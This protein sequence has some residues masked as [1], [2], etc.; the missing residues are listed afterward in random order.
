MD[1]ATGV[2]TVVSSASQPTIA[3]VGAVG[4]SVVLQVTGGPP[5]STG[6]ITA[7]G[8]LTAPQS[9]WTTIAT[10]VFDMSGSFTCTNAFNTG[11][12]GQVYLSVHFVSSP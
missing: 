5:G 4:D 3:R 8:D 7:S 9:A 11:G 2:I 1:P 12:A 6:C 10:N